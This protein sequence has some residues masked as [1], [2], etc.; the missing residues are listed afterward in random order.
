MTPPHAPP[1]LTRPHTM[2]VERRD[3]K[4]TTPYVAPQPPCSS[5]KR[6]SHRGHRQRPSSGGTQTAP[7]RARH[8]SRPAAATGGR[9]LRRDLQHNKASAAQGRCSV[10][11]V[12][13]DKAAQGEHTSR[14]MPAKTV[15][16][17]VRGKEAWTTPSR[18]TDTPAAR[19]AK[20]LDP[21]TL[22]AAGQSHPYDGATR[23]ATRHPMGHMG[24]P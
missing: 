3:T 12:L 17:M 15:N 21:K 14:K 5:Q 11:M 2:P 18:H 22:D 24:S 8:R 6:R 4:G 10:G 13:C 7:L 23:A 20:A 19:T 16:R 1:A 9:A